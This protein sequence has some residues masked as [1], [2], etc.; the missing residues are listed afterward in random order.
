MTETLMIIMAGVLGAVLIYLIYQHISKNNTDNVA[1]FK[2]T[3]KQV[4]QLRPGGSWQ[5]I[6][7]DFINKYI[8]PKENG[9]REGA[10]EHPSTEATNLTQT[11]RDVYTTISSH[12]EKQLNRIPD[13]TLIGSEDNRTLEDEIHFQRETFETN[14]YEEERM[15]MKGKWNIQVEHFFNKVRQA[16]YDQDK[17]EQALNDF[18]IDNKIAVG[19]EPMTTTKI[20]SFIKILIPV[21]LFVTEIYL[22]FNALAENTPGGLLEARYLSFVI[23]SINVGLSFLVGYLILTHLINP[24]DATKKIGGVKSSR[25]FIYGPVLA[26]YL[27][28]LTYV[29][30]MLG[31]Y[32]SAMKVAKDAPREMREQ[33]QD[34]A[35]Y[36]SVWPF[37]NMSSITFD[38]AFLLFLGFFFALITLID[39]YFYKDPI[40]GY[41]RVGDRLASVKKRVQKLKDVDVQ[42]FDKFQEFHENSLKNAHQTRAF[43]ITLWVEYVNALQKLIDRFERFNTDMINVLKKSITNYR[44]SNSQFRRTPAPSYFSI[45]V[46][47]DYVR[48]F[49]EIHSSI[50]DE[51]ET[52]EDVR[53]I[54]KDQKT[55]INAEY[56]DMKIKYSQF[57]DEERVRLKGIIEVLDEKS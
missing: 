9:K 3:K 4:V 56:K 23:A 26:A 20:G 12:Y 18:Q 10:R 19:R 27:F 57:F 33:L 41:S 29:N 28:I 2:N 40:P 7:S 21:I 37:D 55:K 39:A 14:G 8:D 11:E 47:P 54:S 22:N 30:S 53:K 34:N 24:V 31:I 44:A 45:A 43:A 32:R 52:D 35:L 36:D 49:N 1:T 50:M 6:N 46:D 48:Q 15:S 51:Y 38:G 42:L 5:S 16:R 13:F 25:F 17:A